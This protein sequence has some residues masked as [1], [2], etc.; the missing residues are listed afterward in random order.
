MRILFLLLGLALATALAGWV[1]QEHHMHDPL[2]QER[3]IQRHLMQEQLLQE[4]WT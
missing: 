1:T 3:P 2:S 4:E